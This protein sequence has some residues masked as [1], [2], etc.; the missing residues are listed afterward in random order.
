[1]LGRAGCAT[2]TR[3]VSRPSNA[4]IDRAPAPNALI[5]DMSTV[6]FELRDFRRALAVGI[7][8]RRKSIKGT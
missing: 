7:A 4:F 8:Q 1:M 6:R 2:A 3:S 5:G